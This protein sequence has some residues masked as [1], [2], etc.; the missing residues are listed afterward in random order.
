VALCQSLVAAI[1]DNIDRGAYLYDC[2]PMIAKQ[3]KW[4]AARYGMDATFV[5]SDTMKAV[6]AVDMARTLIDRC[7]EQAERL[8][9]LKQ[10]GYLED[11]IQNGTGAAR[12]CGVYEQ[13]HDVHEVAKFLAAQTRQ[14]PVAAGD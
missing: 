10:L 1:S 8:G 2:H 5:D 11:I 12:Q 9:C 14:D 6:P 4:H 13:S 3:N 7:S